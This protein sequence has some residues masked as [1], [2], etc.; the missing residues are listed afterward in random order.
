MID[1]MGMLSTVRFD[2]LTVPS[3]VEGVSESAKNLG[4]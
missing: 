3:E 2:K 4:G 1:F